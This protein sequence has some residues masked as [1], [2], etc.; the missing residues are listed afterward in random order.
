MCKYLYICVCVYKK[1]KE[2]KTYLYDHFREYMAIKLIA[3]QYKPS[4][5][6]SLTLMSPALFVMIKDS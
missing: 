4:K 1:K 2:I 5:L 6:V 3:W